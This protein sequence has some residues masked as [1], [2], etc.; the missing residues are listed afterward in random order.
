VAE[1]GRIPADFSACAIKVPWREV[2]I[3]LPD[4]VLQRLEREA[5][6]HGVSVETL[7][8]AIVVRSRTGHDDSPGAEK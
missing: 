7:I 6:E 1:Q 4:A 5:D 3:E 2:R 8:L